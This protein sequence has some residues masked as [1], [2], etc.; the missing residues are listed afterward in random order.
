MS[1]NS[2]NG[3]RPT[4][5]RHGSGRSSLEKAKGWRGWRFCAVRILSPRGRAVRS[6]RRRARFAKAPQGGKSPA[7]GARFRY[8]ARSY[9]LRIQRLENTP[10]A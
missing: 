2:G 7:P 9:K 3:A 6:K 10:R 1:R 8:C 4:A 5:L